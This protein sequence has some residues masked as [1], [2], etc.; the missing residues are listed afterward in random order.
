M[1][2][3]FLRDSHRVHWFCL[4]I[5]R[6][7][8]SFDNQLLDKP[9]VTLQ[10]NFTCRMRLQTVIRVDRG[11]CLVESCAGVVKPPAAARRVTQIQGGLGDCTP[12]VTGGTPEGIGRNQ[13]TSN[14][15]EWSEAVVFHAD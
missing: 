4:S 6:K 12:S 9:P 5:D 14:G 1:K 15:S 8:K 7:L 2:F 10:T 11:L 13:A 3:F